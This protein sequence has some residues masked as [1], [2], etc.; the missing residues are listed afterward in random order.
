MGDVG[1]LSVGVAPVGNH[2]SDP[3]DE[4]QDEE[5]EKTDFDSTHA[6]ERYRWPQ[7]PPSGTRRVSRGRVG[8]CQASRGSW[9]V[10]VRS[11]TTFDDPPGCIDTPSRQSPASIVRF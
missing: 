7:R 2:D 3:E 9:L 6:A 5:D 8:A 4:H 11:V 1:E 10:S